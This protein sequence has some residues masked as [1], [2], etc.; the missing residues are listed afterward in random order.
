[1]LQ[2]GLGGVDQETR[3]CA[4]GEDAIEGLV[5]MI[6]TRLVR[7][8][9]IDRVDVHDDATERLRAVTD[10]L[11]EAEFRCLGLGH[12]EPIRPRT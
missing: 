6:R 1:V 4:H 9:G 10:D 3:L 7:R 8:T 11:A 12:D 2:H 5:A